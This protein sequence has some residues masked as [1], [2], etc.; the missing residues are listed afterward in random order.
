M[1]NDQVMVEVLDTQYANGD[2]IVHQVRVLEGSI[3]VD[4]EVEARVDVDRRDSLRRNHSATHL[5]HKALKE[6]LGDHV[7][8]AGSIVLPHRLRFDFTHFEAVSKEELLKIEEIVNQKI[9]EAMEVKTQILSLDEA[10][11]EGP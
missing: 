4:M 1:V 6:V 11:A 10:K 7:N 3:E 8:Q 2:L 5:L 9:L